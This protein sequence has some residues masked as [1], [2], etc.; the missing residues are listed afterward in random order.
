MKSSGISS[1]VRTTHSNQMGIDVI[2]LQDYRDEQNL[3]ITY[4]GMLLV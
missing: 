2:A 1:G 3:Q 4:Y